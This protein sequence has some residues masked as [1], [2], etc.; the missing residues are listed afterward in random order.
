MFGSERPLECAYNCFSKYNVCIPNPPAFY[1]EFFNFSMER[2]DIK[3]PYAHPL[4]SIISIL[5]YLLIAYLSMLSGLSQSINSFYFLVYFEVNC[6]IWYTSLLN[7]SA[8][9]SLAS[10][11]YL[12]TI[13]IFF[14]CGKMYI[15]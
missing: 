5:L 7:I 11:Q 13:P 9:I 15:Q 14:N 12:L 8:C 2:L 4:D 6:R 1:Y 10:I 3:H